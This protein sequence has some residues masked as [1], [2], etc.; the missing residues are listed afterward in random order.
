[1]K[2][3]FFVLL[4]CLLAACFRAPHLVPHSP[5]VPGSEAAVPQPPVP[6]G[7]ASADAVAAAGTATPQAA[8]MHAP[9]AARPAYAPASDAP[10]G[11][12]KAQPPTRP[13]H[14]RREL[15]KAVQA[16]LLHKRPAAPTQ[17]N[18]AAG[19]SSLPAIALAAGL[20]GILSLLG[21]FVAGAAVSGGLGGL[22]FA[23]AFISGLLGIILGG[24]AKGRIRRGEDAASGRGKANAGFILGIVDLSIIF[25]L[26]VLVLLIA[27]AVSSSR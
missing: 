19:K 2:T 23:L 12:V 13:V 25:L 5:A 7:Y 18:P 4:T 3:L 6:D 27:A 11:P 17:D 1:M 16:A 8:E 20:I 14:L 21:S 9:P 26:F 15:R 24:I 22:L 10:N